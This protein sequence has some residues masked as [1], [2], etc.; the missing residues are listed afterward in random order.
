LPH[1]FIA[2]LVSGQAAIAAVA[3]A[4]VYGAGNGIVTIT[5]GTLPL[6][7][8]DH[9]TYGTFV[10]RLIAPSFILSAAAPLIYAFVIGRFGEIGALVM[11]IGV[12]FLTFAAASLLKLRFR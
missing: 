9:R 1:C 10:G 4:F 11:S 8:F 12:A 5:R 2:G 7:L 3:F 6:V